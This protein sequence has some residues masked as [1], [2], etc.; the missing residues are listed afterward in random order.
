MN[1]SGERFQA[2]VA[3]L[4]RMLGYAEVRTEV[5]LPSRLGRRESA[6]IVYGH[7]DDLCPVEVKHYRYKS[8]LRLD[9]F[10]KALQQISSYQ[11]ELGAKSGLLVIS[12]PKTFAMAKAGERFPSIEIWD[13]NTLFSLASEFPD[14]FR[15]FE[16]LFEVTAPAYSQPLMAFEFDDRNGAGEAIKR[17]RFLADSLKA[18]P[19]GIKDASAFETACTEALKHLFELDLHGWHEQSNTDDDLHRRDLICRILPK[20][21]VWNLMLTDVGSRYVVF[22]FKN[23]TKQ[24]TQKEVITTER[25]LYP[26]ALR[27]VAILISPQGCTESAT[28]VIQGAM[29]EHGK[30]ILSLSV[31]E[32]VDLLLAKD[33]GGDPNTYLFEKVDRFLMRLGR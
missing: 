13:A 6:D 7:Q 14:L 18:I 12:C 19:S 9:T 8:Q 5:L 30:L 3:E 2:L 11:T 33:D 15:E 26:S 23:Y 20:A 17:G 22:E 16:K 29:R 21:E 25:Y 31:A 27:K 24:I 10:I 28:K 4:L 1:S 32:V